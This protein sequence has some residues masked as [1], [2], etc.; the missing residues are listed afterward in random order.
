LLVKK[1]LFLSHLKQKNNLH[2]I[3]NILLRMHDLKYCLHSTV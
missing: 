3:G 2:I 1:A